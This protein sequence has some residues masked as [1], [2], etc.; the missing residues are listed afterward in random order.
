MTQYTE[1]IA[2]EILFKKEERP[3]WG[4]ITNISP[5]YIEFISRYDF[6]AYNKIYLSFEIALNKIEHL[7]VDIKKIKKDINGYYIYLCYNP[8]IKPKEYLNQ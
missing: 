4:R 1:L 2:V 5:S 3:L 6:K 8:D 7:P